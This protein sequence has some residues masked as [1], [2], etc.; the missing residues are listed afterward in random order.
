MPWWRVYRFGKAMADNDF[1]FFTNS[2]RDSLLGRFQ[3]TL[4]GA[5]YFDV[6][7]GYFRSSGFKNLYP[8]LKDVEKIRILVGLSTDQQV[9]SIVEETK[10]QGEFKF[11]RHEVKELYK[12]HVRQEFE[13][14]E[15]SANTEESVAAFRRMIQEKRLE[16]R[17]VPERDIH[18]KVYI[19]RY[20]EDD[21]DFGSVVT[22]SSNF[23]ENG[24]RANR[25]F[26][27]ELKDKPDV[28]FAL[29][30]FE[31]LWT[32][33]DDITQDYIETID[34]HT[35]LNPAIT[36]YE[37]Y[38]KFL[39]E[40][41]KEEINIDKDGGFMLPDGFMELEYQKQAVTA[42][43]KILNSYNG[44]FL[45]DV[46][47]LGKTY[48]TA[49]LLQ[50]LPAER[51]LIICPPVL[52]D[53]WKS[54]VRDF[55]VGGANVESLGKLD[56]LAD[57]AENYD[58]IV[59]DEAHRFRNEVTWGYEN[60][61]HICQ[62]KKV[63]LVSAT[64]LNNKFDDLLSLI[65]LFQPIRQSSIP[66]IYNLEDFFK[67]QNKKLAGKDKGSKEYLKAV[68][69]ASAV[70]R[71]RVLAHLMVRRT[72]NEIKTYFERDIK[73]QGLRF[74]EPA[75][76]RRIV[77]QF[78]KEIDRVFNDTID[79]LK[80]FSYSRYTPLLFLK[81]KPTEFV[82][83]RQRNIG[84]FMKGILVKRLESSFYAFKQTTDRFVTSYER[85][86]KMFL[87]GTVYISDRV[88]VYD[89]LDNDQEDRLLK[90]VEEEKATHY[91][92]SDFDDAFLVQLRND[93]AILKQIQALWQK[94]DQDPKADEFIRMLRHDKDLANKK[95]I[96]FTESRETSEILYQRLEKEFKGRVLRYSSDGGDFDDQKLSV[97]AARS[98]INANF[99]PR[100]KNQQDQVDILVTTDVLAEGV[101]LHRSNILVNYDLP[102]NPTRILQRVGRINRVGSSFAEY[103]VYNCF[104]TAASNDHLHLEQNIIAKIQAFHNTLGADAKILSDGEEISSHG[105]F[106][107]LNDKRGLDGEDDA[108]ESELKY[109]AVI[110]GVR[111]KD[112]ALFEK[113]KRLPKKSRTATTSTATSD[114][115]VSFFR[116]GALKKFVCCD[117]VRA[118]EID[119]MTAAK[120]FECGT[121]QEKRDIPKAFFDML[122]RNKACL[123]ALSYVESQ[124]PVARSSSSSDA[125]I[126]T[127]IK[128][129]LKDTSIFTEEDDEFLLALKKTL[130]KGMV[131]KKTAQEASKYIKQNKDVYADKLKAL[132]LFKKWFAKCVSYRDTGPVQSVAD[133]REI[134]LSEYFY[135]K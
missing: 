11:S 114:S 2:D 49:L 133:A 132:S 20:H 134:I 106:G 131:P 72:R 118:Q 59:I 42:A 58:V 119:F 135:R 117:A 126:M 26:N 8:A 12:D 105:L 96:V 65:K 41:F 35:W 22:G 99:D 40:Y 78:D 93:L 31:E 19:T 29:A 14:C 13:N 90:M 28:D 69:E 53:S 127:G 121:N 129:M 50:Q 5:R 70:I 73:N 79:L 61:Q 100:E 4:K 62:D 21:R 9:V 68:D 33:S 109:L 32:Q 108:A 27:V 51:K 6:L 39:Y 15:D 116:K 88:N 84:G 54:A 95:V 85:F 98:I 97:E 23:S 125:K 81:E 76:P 91:E 55:R 17:A 67:R 38:L 92:A 47:G 77:Y 63:I 89:L 66:G 43:K 3:K 24:L 7:I 25:E 112:P 104:P 110:R 45:A 120:A 10:G 80:Q 130:E 123:D 71:N 128:F 36:P 101:N 113:I 103:F 102:W 86:I 82:A 34:K 87:D 48:I 115:L 124:E 46:V 60:L 75:D 44:V 37:I 107:R 57:Q 1:R 16:I 56:K 30:R 94:I 52:I 111:D 122:N 74:P 64:P 83:Q 18:A